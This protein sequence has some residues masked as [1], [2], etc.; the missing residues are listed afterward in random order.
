V[1][2]GGKNIYKDGT[3]SPAKLKQMV[4]EAAKG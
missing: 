2:M 1:V 3:L 4:E